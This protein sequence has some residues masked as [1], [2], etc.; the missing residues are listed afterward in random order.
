M[1]VALDEVYRQQLGLADG[2]ASTSARGRPGAVPVPEP[3]Q[4]E[5][6]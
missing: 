1:C 3:V 5:V 4:Q 6:S 2:G